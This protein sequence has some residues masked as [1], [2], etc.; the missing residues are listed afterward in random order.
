MASTPIPTNAPSTPFPTNAP[1]PFD[2]VMAEHDGSFGAPRCATT[3]KQCS[4]GL[5]LDGRATM[6]P[7]P[8][9]AANTIDGCADGSSGTYHSDESNDKIVVSSINGQPLQAGGIAKVEATVYAWSTG[10]A[11]TADF[12]HTEDTNS[13][14]WIHIGSVS[15]GGGGAQTVTSPEFTLSNKSDQAV[16]VRFRYDGAEGPCS[17]GNYDDTDDLVFAVVVPTTSNPTKQPTPQVSSTET[18]MERVNYDIVSSF[19]LV[20]TKS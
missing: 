7:E 11:D 13:I 14:N 15:P 16:R 10:S 12:Y 4:S 20:L 1:T 6:G 19:T 2:G 5:L 8:N 3:G 18:S 9:S 17:N